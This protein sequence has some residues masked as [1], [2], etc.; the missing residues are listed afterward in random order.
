MTIKP[1]ERVDVPQALAA[2]IRDR[3]LAVLF[4]QTVDIIDRD[5][6]SAADLELGCQLA[7]A[8]RQGPLE[9]SKSLDEALEL[10]YAAFADS[11]ATA[12]AREGISAFMEKRKPDFTGL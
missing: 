8:F 6:G 3:L 2:E 5:I 9:L 1:G 10:D 12:A 7:F 11:A 4:S